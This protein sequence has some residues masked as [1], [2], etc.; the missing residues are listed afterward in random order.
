M[1]NRLQQKLAKLAMNQLDGIVFNHVKNNPGQRCFEIDRATLK[2]HH[3]WGT[4]HIL[5]RLEQQQR[6]YCVKHEVAGVLK[7]PGKEDQVV[8]KKVFPRYYTYLDPSTK[9]AL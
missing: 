9:Q 1:L 5:H 6:I 3:Q 8:W 2:S 4:K 7:E